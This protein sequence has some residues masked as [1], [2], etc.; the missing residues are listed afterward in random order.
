MKKSQIIK[1]LLTVGVLGACIGGLVGCSGLGSS[2]GSSK[3]DGA[4]AATVDGTN[5]PESEVTNYIKGFRAQSGLGDDDAWGK[6]LAQGNKTPESFRNDVIEAFITREL[7][8]TH[9]ADRGV[10]VDSSE[11]DKYVDQT[12]SNYDSDDKWNA[13]L[14][15]AG[16]TE[17]DY[18]N[19]IDL[20]LKD[21]KLRDTFATNEEP[22]E[23]DELKA[24][25]TYATS[26]DGAKRSS[27]ILFKSDDK[28]TAQDV[29]NKINSGELD[30]ATAAKQY[31]QDKTSG[32]N[33]GDV[34]WDKTSKLDEDYQKALDGLQKGQVS[35]L[36]TSQFGIHIIK[37]T[38]VYNAP[39]EKAA[40]GTE[41]VKITNLNQIP[42]EWL[43]NI[44]Q[45]LKSQK[46]QEEYQQWLKD[47]RS[48][49]KVT[50]NDMPKGLP[51][52]IDMTKYQKDA[53]N[54]QS[55][56]APGKPLDTG[57]TD[58][59]S[60]DNSDKSTNPSEDAQA[61][62]NDSQS[63]QKDP[64]AATGTNNT[65]PSEQPK[66]TTTSPKSGS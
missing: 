29:L 23:A 40:D 22:S 36:V 39:K 65:T 45:S 9:A 63:N 49:A 4:V 6:Y 50:I 43:S 42:T 57:K 1:A 21:Q 3:D 30:F 32:A 60:A 13:A 25:Q 26:Y 33:G 28:S 54:G 2:S 41:Q 38:D 8:R 19:E 18:R 5:I 61:T 66:D 15:Q 56:A 14:K 12:K 47:L 24:A 37:C 20:Q 55:G 46:Q 53:S 64:S 34:G 7:I 27:H 48:K 35:G 17:E 11:I 51:Y 31:S 59:G 10:K 52:D 62:N 58:S 16:M 44:K